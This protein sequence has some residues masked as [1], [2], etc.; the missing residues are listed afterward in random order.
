M[1]RAV[2]RIILGLEP[3]G[4]SPN[5]EGSVPALSLCRRL[6]GYLGSTGYLALNHSRHPP[7]RA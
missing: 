4:L 3:E 6:V 1:E 7:L 2:I 5:A